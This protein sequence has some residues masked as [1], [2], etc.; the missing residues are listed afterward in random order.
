LKSSVAERRAAP[1]CA[2]GFTLVEIL[3]AMTIVA[4]ALMASIRAV[5][6]LTTSAGDLRG[7][8][9]AQWS[10]ENRLSQIRVQ[11]EYPSVGRR[12]FD[13]SQG[14]LALRCQ[15]DVYSTPNPSF[16]RVEIQV[17]DAA[18]APVGIGGTPTGG[19]LARLIGFAT[20]LP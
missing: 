12:N 3:V 5:G 20:N 17:Y 15:E 2:R 7:R 14:D 9:L 6:S 19:R 10:A 13:C 1:S 18:A 16:R 8:T 4:I 11:R